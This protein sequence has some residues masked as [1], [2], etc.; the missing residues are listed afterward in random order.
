MTHWTLSQLAQASSVAQQLETVGFS[1]ADAQEK[2]AQFARVAQRL[3]AQTD[4]SAA[5]AAA[6]FV[7]GRIEV[8]GKHTDYAG[9]RSVVAA[10]QRGFCGV[11]VARHDDLVHVIDVAK[12][13]DVQFSL[14]PTLVPTQGCWSNYPM[15]VARRLA[16]NFSSARRGVSMAFASDLPPAAGMSSSSALMVMTFLLLRDLNG[17][18]RDPAYLDNIQSLED[19]AGY[20]GTVEN[21]QSFKQLPGDR[22]V[23]TF[24]GSEDH[25]AILCARPGA[26]AQFSYCP[27]R[28]E[29]MIEAPK[30]HLFVIGVSGVVAEKTGAARELYNLASRRASAVTRIWQEATGRSD[31]HLAAIVRS[32]PNAVAHMFNLL[33]AQQHDEFS[34]QEL[35]DRFEQF[36]TESEAII[37]A[38]PD[39]V[40]AESI[41][42]L[43]K[44]AR[45]SQQLGA[46]K[47]GNQIPETVFLTDTA[48]Q[49]GAVAASAQGAG[50]GG[51]VWALV[52]EPD[53]TSFTERWSAAYHGAFPHL[54]A[55]AEFFTTAPARRQLALPSGSCSRQR[56]LGFHPGPGQR[57]PLRLSPG[58]PSYGV[59]NPFVCAKIGVPPLETHSLTNN[60][61]PDP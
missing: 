55:D 45:R 18:E 10:A 48:R 27:V 37:P 29:R 9:G 40:S 43:G 44:L 26:W 16:A 6:W 31:P 2:A 17:V 41:E 56:S 28:L 54:A 50:F 52:A 51:S 35:R 58:G 23:G 34:R 36:V 42:K 4:D 19:L 3:L 57:Y 59:Q 60:E 33:D 32:S 30:D 24:G 49:L 8:F 12:Q 20:L 21:G 46:E 22:G 13:V 15:T 1:P 39:V 47:L 38:L 7:P 53:V 25:T 14:S 61:E 11:A 5:E